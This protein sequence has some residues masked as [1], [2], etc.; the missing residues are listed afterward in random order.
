MSVLGNYSTLK[1]FGFFFPGQF[2]GEA[3]VTY[4]EPVAAKFA[5][6]WFDGKDFNGCK[7]KVQRAMVMP[8]KHMD[9]SSTVPGIYTFQIVFTS[10]KMPL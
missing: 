6:T 10:F 1:K 2:T 4:C 9:E 8:R 3:T 7:I 5:I